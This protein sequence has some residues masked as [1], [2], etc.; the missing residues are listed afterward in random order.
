MRRHIWCWI[1]MIIERGFEW[2][3]WWHLMRSSR[4]Y[5]GWNRALSWGY[6]RMIWGRYCVLLWL[7][8]ELTLV[9]FGWLDM[10]I[11]LLLMWI[12]VV[13]I[14]RRHDGCW[15]Q[16]GCSRLTVSTWHYWRI[17]RKG[18]NGSLIKKESRSCDRLK[19]IQAWNKRSQG[20]N[21]GSWLDMYNECGDLTLSKYLSGDQLL[22]ISTLS[23]V[24]LKWREKRKTPRIGRF[25]RSS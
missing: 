20:R 6:L 7:S 4:S 22:F 1:Y 8:V 13:I 5:S 16:F 25:S 10:L 18:R 3:D 14:I 24:S 21:A 19:I 12:R 17:V 15:I 11:F 23:C 9:W 2:W